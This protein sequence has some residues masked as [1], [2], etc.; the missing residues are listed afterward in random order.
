MESGEPSAITS[1][2]KIYGQLQLF[3]DV[4]VE[5]QQRCSQE[6]R[7]L[8]CKKEPN[9]ANKSGACDDLRTVCTRSSQA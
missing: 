7:A 4:W 1:L 9:E 8:I 3:G 5:M 6:S 2:L